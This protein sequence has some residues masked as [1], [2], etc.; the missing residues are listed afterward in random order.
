MK[1]KEEKRQIDK[2]MTPKRRRPMGGNIDWN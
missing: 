1:E 2:Q